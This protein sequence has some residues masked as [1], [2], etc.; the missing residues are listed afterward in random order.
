MHCSRRITF[1]SLESSFPSEAPRHPKA[2]TNR[3]SDRGNSKKQDEME[4]WND[5]ERG[6]PKHSSEKPVSLPLRPKSDADFLAIEH[7]PSRDRWATAR[8]RAFA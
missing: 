6:K 1:I 3:P 5:N 8:P 7:G 4:W 2:A